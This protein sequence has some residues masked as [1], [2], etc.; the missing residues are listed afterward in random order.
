MMVSGFAASIPMMT[1]YLATKSGVTAQVA[2]PWQGIQLPQS[3][4]GQLSPVANEFTA[5]IGLAKRNER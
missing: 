4:Q 2:N 1:D 5:A 3:S